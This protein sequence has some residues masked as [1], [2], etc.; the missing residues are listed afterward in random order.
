MAF[1]TV[2]NQHRA[3]FGFEKLQLLR[4]RRGAG[5]WW[6]GGLFVGGS[7]ADTAGDK[8]DYRQFAGGVHGKSPNGGAGIMKPKAM[9]PRMW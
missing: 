8:E 7:R 4:V 9:N 2:L 5:R 1:V 6:C 3:D